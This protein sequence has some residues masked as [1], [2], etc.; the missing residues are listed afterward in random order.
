[1]A[2]PAKPD[3]VHELA[4]TKSEAVNTSDVAPGRP[5][6]PKGLS[7]VARKKFKALCALLEKRRHLTDADGELLALFAV[8]YD[9][10]QRALEKLAVEGEIRVY[11]RLD[12]NGQPHDQEKMNL[13]LAVAEKSEKTMLA[14]LDRLGLSPLNRS[15]VR[16]TKSAKPEVV[17]DPMSRLLLNEEEP[18]E[19]HSYKLANAMLKK[20]QEV[21]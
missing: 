21:Q 15:K 4:G 2:M 6:F 10:W 12:S 9:R 13:W 11:V 16:P 18:S 17:A 7:E 8:T 20:H 14:C 3:H 1:M 19:E 5:R